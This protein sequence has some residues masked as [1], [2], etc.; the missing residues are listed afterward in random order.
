MSYM[1]LTAMS[2]LVIACPCAIGLASPI[3]VMSGMGKAA[4]FSVLI[5]NGEALQTVSY[6]QNI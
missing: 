2:V 3:S 5:R 6:L 4:E 1:I